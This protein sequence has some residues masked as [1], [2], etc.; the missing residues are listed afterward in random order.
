MIAK[1][2]SILV[3]GC[4]PSAHGP[5]ARACR[6]AASEAIDSGPASDVVGLTITRDDG[7]LG[8]SW[9]TRSRRLAIKTLL[10]AATPVTFPPGRLRLVT[11]PGLDRIAA[12]GEDDRDSR[13]RGLGG[14]R[15]WDRR[16]RRSRPRRRTNS[17]A[18]AGRRSPMLLA[19][20]YSIGNVAAV[21]VASFAQPLAKCR[22]EILV[23]CTVS[24]M[25]KSNH[26]QRR[27]LRPRHQRPRRRAAKS[28]DE[29]PPSHPRPRSRS[30]GSLSRSGLHWNRLAGL[31]SAGLEAPGR[32]SRTAP[33]AVPLQSP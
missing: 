4:S 12:N 16:S 13:G 31:S 10:N 3:V 33:L 22:H 5:A 28:R 8:T 1:A 21:D 18:S 6:A 29:L 23:A 14:Q 30:R 19:Q 9:R 32:D 20:R 24:G 2:A 11:K 7:G 17:A 26:R 27:L 25:K 15:S